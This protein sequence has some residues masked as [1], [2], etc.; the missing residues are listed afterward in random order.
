MLLVL[1]SMV[2]LTMMLQLRLGFAWHQ[3]TA[4]RFP[5][6]TARA[7]RLLLRHCRFDLLEVFGGKANPPRRGDDV[8]SLKFNRFTQRSSPNCRPSDATWPVA[9][10][11]HFVAY[12]LL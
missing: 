5:L 10:L 9:P 3:F 11:A 2:E 6:V 8:S 4:V 12:Q 7:C 1:P